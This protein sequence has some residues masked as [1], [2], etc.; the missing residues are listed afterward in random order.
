M[1]CNVEKI[2]NAT[3]GKGGTMPALIEK[4]SNIFILFPVISEVCLLYY[5]LQALR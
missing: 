4:S 3:G 5:V 2:K 1:R